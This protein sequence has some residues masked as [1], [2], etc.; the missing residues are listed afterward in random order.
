MMV[1]WQGILQRTARSVTRQLQTR[2]LTTPSIRERLLRDGA[3]WPVPVLSAS[4]ASTLRTDLVTAISGRGGFANSDLLYYKAHLM[5]SAVDAL[6]RHPTIIHA[7]QSALATDD[8]LLWDS[9]V[10]L[11]PPTCDASD[12][13]GGGHFPWHQDATYW[14]L[15]PVN[16]ALSCWVALSD[17]S[18]AHGCM[19]VVRGSHAGGQRDHALRPGEDGSM[20]RRGQQ[21]VGV[22]DAG[23]EAMALRAGEM[24]LHHPLA[25]HCSGPNTTREARVGV[26]LVFVPPSTVPHG[27][28]GSATLVAG[29][30][31]ASHWALSPASWRPATDLGA[32]AADDPEALAVHA[33]ALALHRGELQAT[34][35]GE[36]RD[37]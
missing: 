4:E 13:D 3:V 29:R 7:A 12:A 18:E 24:S 32:A 10:P 21:V 25:L 1:F 19:R 23:A 17:A 15:E 31:D 27:G 6:A 28:R 34:L 22:D 20:L 11:K 37:G 33:E 26:V 30:C 16:G 8:L 5:F 14:G 9:S 35:K 2:S 36:G